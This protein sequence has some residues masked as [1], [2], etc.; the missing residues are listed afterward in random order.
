MVN[1]GHAEWLGR[2]VVIRPLKI[3]VLF[4]VQK[5]SKSN[6]RA[7]KNYKTVLKNKGYLSVNTFQSLFHT[8]S[9]KLDPLFF[10]L[11]FPGIW[12]KWTRARTKNRTF[13]LSGRR[14]FSLSYQ[15][16]EAPPIFFWH[17]T[18]YTIKSGKAADYKSIVGI[19]QKEGLVPILLLIWQHRS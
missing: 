15:K 10:F 8:K 7:R 18:D 5:F 6:A 3:N 9:K 17:D 16:K 2:G 12:A 1:L 13:I 4:L 14:S 19:I 11:V